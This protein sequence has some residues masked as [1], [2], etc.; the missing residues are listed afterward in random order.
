[1]SQRPSAGKNL[2]VCGGCSNFALNLWK[3][4]VLYK[5]CILVHENAKGGGSYSG[6]GCTHIS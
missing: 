1:M 4:A 2:S 3:L 6:V 5:M